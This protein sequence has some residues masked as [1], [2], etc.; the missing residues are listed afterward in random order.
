MAEI[1]NIAALK[2][3]QEIIKAMRWKNLSLD[4]FATNYYV[5]VLYDSVFKVQI[6]AGTRLKLFC[7]CRLF[8]LS[9]RI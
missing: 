5:V 4:C 8:W 3:H 9:L 1:L 7:R 2:V 6:H